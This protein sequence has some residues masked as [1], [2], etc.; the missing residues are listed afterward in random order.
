[1]HPIRTDCTR[2]D[3]TFLR[4]ALEQATLGRGSNGPPWMKLWAARKACLIL[5]LGSEGWQGLTGTW[6]QASSVGLR[7]GT[8]L[9][10]DTC[11]KVCN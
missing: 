9:R 5:G 11:R 6:N 7:M 1:M 8:T 4:V 3:Y 2:S 10:F